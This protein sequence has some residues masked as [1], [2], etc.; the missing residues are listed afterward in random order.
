MLGVPQGSPGLTQVL[1]LRIVLAIVIGSGGAAVSAVV[2]CRVSQDSV[3]RV[4]TP[5][6]QRPPLNGE[7]PTVLSILQRASA[8]TAAA[9]N[10]GPPTTPATSNI[11]P[12]PPPAPGTLNNP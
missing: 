1:G 2:P 12:K 4:S 10:E 9:H 3:S 6:P 7:P 5:N 8:S 11:V